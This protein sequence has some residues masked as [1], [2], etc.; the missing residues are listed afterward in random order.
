MTEPIDWLDWAKDAL[1]WG[2]SESAGAAALIGIGEE[3]RKM[4][5][6]AETQAER[7]A[8]CGRGA[9]GFCMACILQNDM[10]RPRT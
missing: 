9:T 1:D 7:V 3:L 2:S 6:R 4:N 8:I 10:L 5:E